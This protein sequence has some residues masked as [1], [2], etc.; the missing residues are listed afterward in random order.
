MR[1]PL[2]CKWDSNCPRD[3]FAPLSPPYQ[4]LPFGL[5]AR[6]LSERKKE[7]R[8]ITDRYQRKQKTTSKMIYALESSDKHLSWQGQDG[9]IRFSANDGKISVL[10]IGSADIVLWRVW[11]LSLLACIKWF[12]ITSGVSLRWCGEQ[13]RYSWF[14]VL[15][16][17]CCF[18]SL[19]QCFCNF[20]EHLQ[21][22][23]SPRIL[24]RTNEL[25]AES[26]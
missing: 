20:H 9:G 7:W 18:S 1:S 11:I 17:V 14:Y 10:I 2:F 25:V 3:E 26:V 23:L 15:G 13:W 21:R 4:V 6:C 5:R 24:Y 8:K 19:E 16:K 22:V 12:S